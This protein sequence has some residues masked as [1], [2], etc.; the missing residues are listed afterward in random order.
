MPHGNQKKITSLSVFI[1]LFVLPNFYCMTA[2]SLIKDC[3]TQILLICESRHIPFNKLPGLIGENKQNT[4]G[5]FKGKRTV[6]LYKIFNYFKQLNIKP[7]EVISVKEITHSQGN[8]I[9]ASRE[10]S[11]GSHENPIG[12]DENSTCP[13]KVGSF[14]DENSNHSHEN[15]NGNREISSSSHENPTSTDE[16]STCPDKVGSFTDENSNYSHENIKGSYENV[17]SSHENATLNFQN[18]TSPEKI[19]SNTTSNLEL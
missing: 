17:S 16:N 9:S 6:S 12:T 5:I 3:L 2:H 10:N 4:W 1:I 19:G 13:D 7:E 18:I 15:R 11:T 14:T 8:P